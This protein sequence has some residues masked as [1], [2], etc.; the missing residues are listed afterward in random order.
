MLASEVT[1][2]SYQV[3]LSS[4]WSKETILTSD[5]LTDPDHGPVCTTADPHPPLL[6][7]L[8]AAQV[9]LASDWSKD[10]ILV[11]DWPRDTVIVASDWARGAI[12]TSD[13]LSSCS[14][15]RLSDRYSLASR[16][17]KPACE[18]A[19]TDQDPTT[20]LARSVS[21]SSIISAAKFCLQPYSQ[22]SVSSLLQIRV[23]DCGSGDLVP[24]PVLPPV[25][26]LHAH[27]LHAGDTR[28][29]QRGHRDPGV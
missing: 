23:P 26:Q 16:Y 21:P 17:N 11:S 1:Y 18:M 24:E 3:M 20:V 4:H 6:P 15:S 19:D 25:R 7:P 5:W 9:I 22:F 13:W 12:L 14:C 10:T 2:L 8:H 29:A 28:R 27:P